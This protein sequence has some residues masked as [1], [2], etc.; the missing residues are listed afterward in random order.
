MTLE[1]HDGRVN[2]LLYPFNEST[3][4]EPKHLLSGG[5]DFSVI[6]WDI[7]EGV[8]LHTFTVHGGEISQ[9]LVPPNNCNVS[10]YNVK[11]LYWLLMLNSR[12]LNV[13]YIF[14]IAKKKKLC[15]TLKGWGAFRIALVCPDKGGKVGGICVLISPLLIRFF[16][17][18]EK[19]AFL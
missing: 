7:H 18:N 12:M 4:Y 14:F 5:A 1:G 2:C 16:L 8:K 15:P 6:L 13:L 11:H 19:K 9:L 10:F 3:R 17:Y